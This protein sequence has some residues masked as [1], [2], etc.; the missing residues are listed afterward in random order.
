MRRHRYLPQ[1]YKHCRNPVSTGGD[2]VHLVDNPR[3][4]KAY[5]CFIIRDY[6]FDLL[7]TR[8]NSARD[9]LG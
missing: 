5:A 8:R 9:E 2:I 4:G 7:E 1:D 3:E 6:S